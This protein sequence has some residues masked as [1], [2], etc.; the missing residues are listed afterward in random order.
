MRRWGSISLFAIIGL[1]FSYLIAWTCD[2]LSRTDHDFLYQQPPAPMTLQNVFTAPVGW[3]TREWVRAEGF[4]VF[5]AGVAEMHWF[6]SG[7]SAD[8][9]E[10]RCRIRHYS[11]WPLLCLV[12]AGELDYQSPKL[13]DDLKQDALISRL[14]MAWFDGLSHPFASNIPWNYRSKKLA[15]RPL[16]AHLAVNTLFW[17]L[18]AWASLRGPSR[19]RRWN[20]D[21]R[22]LC[23]RCAYDLAGLETCPEC[24]TSAK[25]RR[26]QA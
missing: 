12:R 9:T 10:N 3:D 20:R 22:G 11:G 17:G 26:M 23:V 13:T 4:G 25:P 5:S 2:S 15:L 6:S 21:R 24:G 1:A 7:M 19:I 16:P 14:N 18:L 8:D